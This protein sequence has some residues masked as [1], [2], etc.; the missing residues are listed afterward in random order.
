MRLLL[1]SAELRERTEQKVKALLHL[2]SQ[3][4]GKKFKMPE[5]RYDLQGKTAGLAYEK[6]WLLR[7]NLVL[8]V[9]NQEK[10]FNETI[11]HEVAHLVAGK[12]NAP[13]QMHGKEWAEVMRFFGVEPNCYHDYDLSK[14]CEAEIYLPSTVQRCKN[15]PTLVIKLMGFG[16]GEEFCV[17][18]EC[19]KEIQRQM[20]F[21]FAIARKLKGGTK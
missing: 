5:I 10:F 14:E 13:K 6:R 19:L 8:F 21:Q 17:C 20:G 11:P 18:A 3:N 12:L 2:A 16:R 4:W 15:P 7:F 9:E 1:I